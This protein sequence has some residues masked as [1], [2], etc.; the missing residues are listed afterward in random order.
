MESKS[1]LLYSQDP[2]TGPN[3]ETDEHSPHNH[4][5][6]CKNNFNIILHCLPCLPKSVD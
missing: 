2:A 1:L 6:Y 4:T 3:Y 5:C